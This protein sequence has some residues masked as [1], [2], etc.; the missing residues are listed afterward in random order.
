M[1]IFRDRPDLLRR[2]REGDR[3]A[4]EDV[5]WAY[6]DKVTAIIRFGFSAPVSGHK[7]PGLARKADDAAEV[8]Q[9]VFSRVFSE[10]AR[11]AFDGIREFGPYLFMVTRN[12]LADWGRKHSREV[13]AEWSDQFDDLPAPLPDE[14]PVYADADT[15]DAVRMYLEGLSNEER[16]V[17]NALYVQGKPQ[18]QASETLGLSR[19]KIRTID[20]HIREGLRR[21]LKRRDLGSL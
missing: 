17:H 5:Y 2:F 8:L 20:Q 1:P 6:V 10:K 15:M 13:P 4:M 19:Q 16:R 21:T 3:A 18:R 11:L 7:V 9:E 14:E 12:A